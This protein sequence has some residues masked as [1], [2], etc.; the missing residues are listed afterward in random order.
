MHPDVARALYGN[1]VGHPR[2]DYRSPESHFATERLSNQLQEVIKPGCLFLDL[3]CNVGRFCFFSETFGA[4]P[5][6]VDCLIEALQFA[7]GIRRDIESKAR[8]VGCAFP[9]LPF[10]KHVF[11]LALFPDNMVLFSV[12][13]MV[14]LAES[15]HRVLRP[16]GLLCLSMRDGLEHVMEHQHWLECYDPFAGYVDSEAEIP[17]KGRFKNPYYFWTLVMAKYVLSQHFR[18]RQEERIDSCRY[19][20]VFE[21]RG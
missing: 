21:N 5:V 17:G 6:G 8:F 10:Q 2:T 16:D 3:G 12:E 11:D 9:A 20:L 19:W 18:L 1:S 4:S 15:L 13:E 14:A 7:E